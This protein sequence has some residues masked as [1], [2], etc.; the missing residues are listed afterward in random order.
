[1]FVFND[2]TELI[3]GCVLLSTDFYPSLAQLAKYCLVVVVVVVASEW[4]TLQL[5]F[6]MSTFH[7][8]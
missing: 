7:C 8:N 3:S 4:G 1:M 6:A 2:G 5:K